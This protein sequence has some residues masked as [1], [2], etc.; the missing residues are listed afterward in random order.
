MEDRVFTNSVSEKFYP[1]IVVSAAKRG[2]V[3]QWVRSRHRGPTGTPYLLRRVG[4]VADGIVIAMARCDRR[5]RV[6][7]HVP[8]E[9]ESYE[10]EVYGG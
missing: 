4:I 9:S 10:I 5:G 1:Q 8:W 3:V 7:W 6:R 2:G